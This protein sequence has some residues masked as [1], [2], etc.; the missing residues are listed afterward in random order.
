[1][2][3]LLLFLVSSSFA[4]DILAAP[5]DVH[6]L[7]D[8]EELPAGAAAWIAGSVVNVRAEARPEAPVARRLVAGTRVRVVE[9]IGPWVE[10][11]VGG[12]TGWVARELLS[13][14]GR[15]GDLDGDG[16][17]ERVV[18][19]QGLDGATRAWL[20]EGARVQAVKLYPWPDPY[21]ASWSIVPGETAGVP[22]LRVD[23]DQDSCGSYPSVWLSYTGDTLRSALS[24]EPWSDGG[25]GE[26]YDVTFVEPGRVSVRREVYGELAPEVRETACVLVGGVYR[27]S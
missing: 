1:M 25:Y 10:V 27:C 20:R 21:I 17:E 23:L 18:V 26:G 7:G 6:F 15:S 3:A 12:T 24:V 22:L 2:T 11:S 16:V 9:D 14:M 8:T 4:A 5:R 19:A 13:T